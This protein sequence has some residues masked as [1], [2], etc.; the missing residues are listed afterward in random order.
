M[1]GEEQ[2]RWKQDLLANGWFQ[3]PSMVWTHKDHPGLHGLEVAIQLHNSRP[4]TGGDTMT[5][6][7]TPGPW[8]ILD[9]SILCDN[10]NA[11]GNF[12]IASFDRC[13]ERLTEEDHA[14]AR[15]IA[16]APDLLEACERAAKS[17]HHPACPN[18][19]QDCTCHVRLAQNA[20]TKAKATNL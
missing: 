14:N 6:E 20:V 17:C 7:H 4:R 11:Y 1:T 15:L 10:V 12:H 3:M 2:D 19:G 18:N 13:D 5:T 16:A 9:H 8:R